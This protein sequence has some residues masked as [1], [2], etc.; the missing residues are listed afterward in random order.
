M[1]GPRFDRVGE[2][3]PLEESPGIAAGP[4]AVQRQGSLLDG[5]GRPLATSLP[6]WDLVPPTEFLQRHL[7]QT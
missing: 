5:S 4:T 6:E 2:T 1:P 7:Q 3:Q